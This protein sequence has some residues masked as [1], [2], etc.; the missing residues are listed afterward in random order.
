MHQ[1]ITK[2]AFE[3]IFCNSRLSYWFVYDCFTLHDSI[4]AAVKEIG[5]FKS[6]EN[7]SDLE[8]S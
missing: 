3:N 6:P 2:L 5:Y 7:K 4:F 1:D 8:Q